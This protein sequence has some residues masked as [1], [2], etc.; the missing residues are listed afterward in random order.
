MWLG[1]VLEIDVGIDAA[2]C[3]LF[4]Y[5]IGRLEKRTRHSAGDDRDKSQKVLGADI[6]F[7]REAIPGLCVCKHDLHDWKT[8]NNEQENDGCQ[9]WR[10]DSGSPLERRENLRT[11]KY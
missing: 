2:G 9:K 1:Y 10:K 7:A 6:A 5:L 11:A 8:T 4:G 3:T